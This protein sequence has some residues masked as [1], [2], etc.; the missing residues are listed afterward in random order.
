MGGICCGTSLNFHSERL[1]QCQ[2]CGSRSPFTAPLCP[3]VFPGWEVIE[4]KKGTD[5]GLG[6]AQCFVWTKQD[7]QS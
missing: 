2:G 3:D 5:L 6:C 4:E 1:W 7:S